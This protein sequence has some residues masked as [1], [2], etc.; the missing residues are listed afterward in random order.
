M[1]A[2]GVLIA[3]ASTA[4]LVLALCAAKPHARHEEVAPEPPPQV[5]L[6]LV[7]PFPDRDWTV[8]LT[9][10][11][12]EP[13]RIVA[14]PRLFSF[15]VTSAGHEH[16]C[17]LPNDMRPSTDVAR[18]LVVPPNRTWAAHVDPVLY[19]FGAAQ[20]AALAPGAVVTTKFGFA[21]GRNAPPFAIAPTA[22]D[23][24][25]GPTRSVAAPAVTLAAPQV[26]VDAGAPDVAP[27]RPS[28]AY[29][30]HLKVSLPARDDVL[31][32]F[33]RTVLVTV[34]NEGDR[35]VRTLITAPTIGFDLETPSSHVYRCGADAP[36]TAIAELLTTLAPRART[37]MSID[38]GAVC[39]IYLREPGLYRVRPVLDTRKTTPP[40]GPRPFWNGEVIGAPM[41]LRVRE[42]EAPP[43]PPR[44]EPPVDPAKK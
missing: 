13:V 19:C 2:R 1:R 5:S 15:D 16:H 7:A 8:T 20:E 17:V 36:A 44:L 4:S 43:P 11:G 14:D 35:P 26:P 34:V 12:T 21:P 33:E 18:T 39:G 28:N 10:T 24:G 41:L 29:P 22:S 31:R 32:A 37:V 30:V 38:I 6:A 40:P 23:A 9:N 27:Q 42:G 25:V 3:A